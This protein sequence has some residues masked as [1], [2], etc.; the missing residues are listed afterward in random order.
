MA[1]RLS[2]S[3]ITIQRQSCALLAVGACVASRTHSR[4]TSRSTGRVRSRRWRT[5]RVVVSSSS[6]AERST[7]HSN[8]DRAGLVDAEHGQCPPEAE[9]NGDAQREA[10]DLWGGNG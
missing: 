1:A 6:T 9:K 8:F 3:V 10:E 5:A 4:I 7:R 2:P